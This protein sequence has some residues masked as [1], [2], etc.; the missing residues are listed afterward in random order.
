[1]ADP[2]IDPSETLIYG[3]FAR[4]QMKAVCLGLVEPLDGAVR[5]AIKSQA[6][7]DAAMRA[8]LDRAPSPPAVVGDP[9]EDARDVLVRFGKYLESLKGRP[10]DSAD[11]FDEPPSVMA[12]RRLTKLVAAVKHVHAQ[13]QARADRVRGSA[14]WLEDLRDTHARLQALEKQER[15]RK[16]SEADLRPEIAAARKA[17]LEVYTANKALIT[18][19]L[20]HAGKLAMLPLVFDDLAEVHRAP[21]VRDDPE[22]P[23]PPT[24]PA[25]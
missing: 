24:P 19:V 15:A 20:R 7:A 22:P 25:G 17:W 13:L 9:I 21:G 1:M 8:V 16:V 2:Y 3:A 6:D 10:V 18:G 23:A 12:R 11:F 14:E 5:F 4:D